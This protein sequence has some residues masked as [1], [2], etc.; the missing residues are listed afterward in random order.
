MHL[1]LIDNYNAPAPGNVP[2]SPN[3]LEPVYNTDWDYDEMFW[4][5]LMCA[6]NQNPCVHF[7]LDIDPTKMQ[8]FQLLLF[9]DFIEG[10]LLNNI[11]ARI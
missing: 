4:R 8:L 6:S 2:A 7:S 1:V 3:Q 10:L 5:R 11:N 9:R